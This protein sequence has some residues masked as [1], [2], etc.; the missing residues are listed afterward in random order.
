MGALRSSWLWPPGRKELGKLGSIRS[1]R[2]LCQTW[3]SPEFLVLAQLSPSR[4]HRLFPWTL[5]LSTVP[6]ALLFRGPPPR[7]FPYVKH[8]FCPVGHNFCAEA[9]KCGENSECKNWNTKATCECKNGY[10][11]AQGNSAYCEGKGQ[12][13]PVGKWQ[14]SMLSATK[15]MESAIQ[16]PPVLMLY[17]G[18]FP[19]ETKIYTIIKCP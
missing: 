16:G 9:P 18:R 3:D 4:C 17:P 7:S 19:W 8:S 11:S 1:I 5:T 13:G 12:R 6:H 10:I 2:N 15:E 14:R